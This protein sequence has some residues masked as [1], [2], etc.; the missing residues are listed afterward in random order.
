MRALEGAG[1]TVSRGASRVTVTVMPGSVVPHLGSH[2]A[3]LCESG[4][5]TPPL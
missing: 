5:G 3:V 4:L 2:S 1:H